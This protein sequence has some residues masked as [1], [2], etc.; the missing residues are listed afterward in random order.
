M[1]KERFFAHSVEQGRKHHSGIGV[2]K[3]N[4][5]YL[6]PRRERLESLIQREWQKL[7]IKR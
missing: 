6:G 7:L 5:Q 3:W 2:E 1:K 4:R